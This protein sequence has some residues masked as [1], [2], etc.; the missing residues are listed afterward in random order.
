M[1]GQTDIPN[2][3]VRAMDTKTKFV[4]ILTE[5]ASLSGTLR[6]TEKLP[7]IITKGLTSLATD[8]NRK[9]W[10]LNVKVFSLYIYHNNFDIKGIA[11]GVKKYLVELL[12]RLVLNPHLL[13]RAEA[14]A[15]INW[16]HRAVQY[17]KCNENK[18][19]KNARQIQESNKN[20]TNNK[21]DEKISKKKKKR[22]K[23]KKVVKVIAPKPKLS[24]SQLVLHDFTHKDL[25]SI[26]KGSNQYGLFLS[27]GILQ[28]AAHNK[29]QIEKNPNVNFSNAIKFGEENQLKVT[30]S[31]RL[32]K[33]FTEFVTQNKKRTAG[34]R[35]IENN[36]ILTHLKKIVPQNLITEAEAFVDNES[37]DEATE[38]DDNNDQDE[39][40]E[41]EQQTKQQNVFS[42][43]DTDANEEYENIE[44]V[45]QNIDGNIDG[46]IDDNVSDNIDGNIDCDIP[47]YTNISDNIHGYNLTQQNISENIEDDIP[48]HTNSADN[49]DGN[50]DDNI[51]DNKVLSK[52]SDDS[53]SFDVKDMFSKTKG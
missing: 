13:P 4:V 14:V 5:I 1:S 46:N 16:F 43:C 39:K 10:K 33:T 18:K 3:V 27:L 35:Y 23:D 21:T 32:G 44:N 40:M 28:I 24:G 11:K 22:K 47:V 31:T 42:P 12:G 36:N 52:D 30:K 49:I 8:V 17:H 34:A 38:S 9:Q 41:V 50:M 15:F 29:G 19:K 48:V 6:K 51:D 26:K 2:A 7:H 37:D 53:F 20:N 25:E 45:S